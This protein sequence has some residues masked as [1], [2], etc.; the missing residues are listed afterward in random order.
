MQTAGEMQK[1]NCVDV[2]EFFKFAP[3]TAR[4]LVSEWVNSFLHYEGEGRE[5]RY[6]LSEKYENIL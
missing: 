4:L 6:F 3:R 2:T 5:C 1:V